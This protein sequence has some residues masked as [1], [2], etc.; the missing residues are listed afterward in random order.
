MENG[1]Q[2]HSPNLLSS[3]LAGLTF[4]CRTEFQGC[5]RTGTDLEFFVDVFEMPANGAMFH[6]EAICDFLVGQSLR[7][8]LQDFAFARRKIFQLG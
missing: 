8:E 7:Q 5:L 3:I 6:A 4:L 2:T 1:M